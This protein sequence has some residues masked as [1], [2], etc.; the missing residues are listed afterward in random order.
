MTSS[1]AIL[2]GDGRLPVQL[3]QAAPDAL[4]VVFEGMAHQLTT[5]NIQVCQFEKLHSLF[6]LLKDHEISQVVMAGA[7]SRPQLDPA[8][9][10]TFMENIAPDFIKVLQKGDDTVLRYV[11]TLFEDQ[12]FEVVAP[13]DIALELT[14]P[15]GAAAG[16]LPDA[17]LADVAYA[18]QILHHMSRLDIGQGVVVEGGHV[19]GIETLQGTEA[20]LDFV[21]TT[22]SSL[23]SSQGGVLVKRPKVDQ[24]MRVDVPTIGPQTI[25][26]VAKAGLSGIVISPDNVLVLDRDTTLSLAKSLGVFILA[27]DP[28]L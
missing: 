27:Q 24:D 25:R 10:D 13:Q 16:A 18:D 4:C 12:G 26:Q 7:M 9:F 17:Q 3:H 2:A 15:A 20:L 23:R 8:K 21:A 11:I 6:K 5:K 22:S 19:L 14:L 28:E 1:L